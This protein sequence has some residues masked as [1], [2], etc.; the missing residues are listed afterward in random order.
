[1]CSSYFARYSGYASADG[2]ERS[3]A[4]S[5][6]STTM[7]PP[8]SSP[9]KLSVTCGFA[10]RLRTRSPAWE[11]MT[12]VSS[13]SQRNQ[14]GRG[15]GAP[16]GETVVI[17][18]TISSRRWRATRAPNS[19]SRSI[20]RPILRSRGERPEEADDAAQPAVAVEL[21]DVQAADGDGAV[22]PDQLPR[23]ADEA[24]VLVHAARAPEP[25]ARR[26][27]TGPPRPSC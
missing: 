17:Q 8:S 10:A 26:T 6:E 14:T 12:T 9:R 23:V 19:L 20:T 7:S 25:V 3:T 13:P 16:E 4:A 5:P 18:T 1:M 27:A 2:S 15:S 24:V 11:Y 21:A 22:R